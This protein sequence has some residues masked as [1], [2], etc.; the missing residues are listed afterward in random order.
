VATSIINTV[1]LSGSGLLIGAGSSAIGYTGTAA[2]I[3][4]G[5]AII[6]IVAVGAALTYH[7]SKGKTK[8]EVQID[9]YHELWDELC[10]KEKVDGVVKT[11]L[12]QFEKQCRT[13]NRF[14]EKKIEGGGS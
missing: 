1:S 7:L 11:K 8:A 9:V 10:A 2:I 13:L 4:T 12:E 5:G 3:I 14:T 6:P